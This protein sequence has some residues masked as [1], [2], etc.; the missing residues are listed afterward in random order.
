MLNGYNLQKDKFK[1]IKDDKLFYLFLQNL[2]EK[3]INVCEFYSSALDNKLKKTTFLTL[4]VNKN[5]NCFIN[6]VLSIAEM[7][8][9]NQLQISF[10]NIKGKIT[11]TI[12]IMDDNREMLL[13]QLIEL[14]NRNAYSQ[15]EFLLTI[16]KFN[17]SLTNTDILYIY[18]ILGNNAYLNIGVDLNNNT[19]IK[20]FSYVVV[21]LERVGE[22]QY[23]IYAVKKEDLDILA[24]T[25]ERK[26]NTVLENEEIIK[27]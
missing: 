16:E 9:L 8:K 6:N 5:S 25:I 26:K 27:R 10:D 3:N 20:E 22:L 24:T 7:I 23:G 12:S 15:N 4:D 13:K 18:N 19:E 21:H 1:S 14:V 11:M 17:N 2:K